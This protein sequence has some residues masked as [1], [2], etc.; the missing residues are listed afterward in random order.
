[1][2]ART[3][4]KIGLKESVNFWGRSKHFREG[5]VIASGAMLAGSF[6]MR[7]V[8]LVTVE[9]CSRFLLTEVVCQ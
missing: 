7:Q 9:Y 6:L 2:D 4:Y 1:M 3:G 8:L 5:P